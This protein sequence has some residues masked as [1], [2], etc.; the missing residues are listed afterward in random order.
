M[1]LKEINTNLTG[2]KLGAV[3]I[4]EHLQVNFDMIITLLGVWSRDP[5]S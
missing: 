5:L 4:V 1:D 2:L 3:N